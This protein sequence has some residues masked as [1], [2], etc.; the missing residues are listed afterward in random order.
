MNSTNLM[1][2]KSYCSPIS[3]DV[4]EDLANYHVIVNILG[5]ISSSVSLF[6][7][8]F[9]VLSYKCFK[10][11]VYNLNFFIFWLAFS[12]ILSTLCLM[13]VAILGLLPED[14]HGDL[15]LKSFTAVVESLWYEPK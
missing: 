13:L 7:S 5:I 10:G 14:Y 6:G 4:N 1:N 12:N 8:T 2:G 9:V 11:Y 3:D 15:A